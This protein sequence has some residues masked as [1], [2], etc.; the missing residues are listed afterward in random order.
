MLEAL[1]GSK[2]MLHLTKLDDSL[3]Y[4]VFLL[5]QFVEVETKSRR[6]LKLCE[7]KN[8]RLEDTVK[9]LET[10]LATLASQPEQMNAHWRVMIDDCCICQDV[11]N[12]PNMVIPCGHTLCQVC[13]D[14]LVNAHS[15]D[16][17]AGPLPVCPLCR[18][19]ID[20]AACKLPGVLR[21][22]ENA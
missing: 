1:F 22:A 17:L 14:G 12:C 2:L 16:P 13:L 5:P 6:A 4:L 15:N 21:V 10:K 9:Q 18:R 20:Q 19:G 7:D 3:L 11:Q 8:R